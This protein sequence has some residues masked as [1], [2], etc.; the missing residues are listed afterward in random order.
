MERAYIE[1][2]GATDGSIIAAIITAHIPTK[3]GRIGGTDPGISSM[4]RAC[5]RV[6]SQAPAAA[7]SSAAV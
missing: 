7:S 5:N 3:A 4:R 2:S 6:T 1:A